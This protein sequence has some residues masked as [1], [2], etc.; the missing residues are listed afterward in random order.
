MRR[1]TKGHVTDKCKLS[2]GN[3]DQTDMDTPLIGVSC[4]RDRPP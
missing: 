1:D 3:L 4:V 2:V